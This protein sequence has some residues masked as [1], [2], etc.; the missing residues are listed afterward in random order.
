MSFQDWKPVILHR[1][2]TKEQKLADAQRKGET[3][4][5]S[6]VNGGKNSQS[7]PV[8]FKDL[9]DDKIREIPHISKELGLAIQQARAT[10]KMTQKDLDHACQ[11]PVN[12]TRDFE[13]GSA[14]VDHRILQKMSKALGVTLKQS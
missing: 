3:V 9:E 6:R 7:T 10:K 14:L 12:T 8:N 1:S 2:K 11:L 5:K 13:N 4:V